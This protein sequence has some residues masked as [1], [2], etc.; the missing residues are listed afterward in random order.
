MKR[1]VLAVLFLS[2]LGAVSVVPAFA[3][4]AIYTNGPSTYNTSAW[5]IIG[6]STAVSGSLSGFSVSDSFT[7]PWNTKVSGVNF[8]AWLDSG[9]SITGVDWS[10]GTTPFGATLDSGV[11]IP[12]ATLVTADNGDG[13]E[14]DSEYFSVTPGLSLDTGTTY[15][16]TLDNASVANPPVV[17]DSNFNNT[18]GPGYVAWDE[19]NGPSL[20][21]GSFAGGDGGFWGSAYSN[22]PLIDLN[23]PGASASES[24]Q[25][26][27]ATPEP[28]SFLLLGTGLAG[29]AGLL[30]FMFKA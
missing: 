3:D 11:A 8:V 22:Q 21:A 30:R 14:I 25:V 6:G 7:V 12:T 16:L 18:G 26:I 10:I 29:L 13:Y 28:G 19:S 24:F 23:L 1:T 17:Y 9:D 4:A 2:L 5:T 20:A 27:G 15:Y